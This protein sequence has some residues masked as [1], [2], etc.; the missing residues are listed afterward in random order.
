MKLIVD[1]GSTKTDWAFA[2]SKSDVIIA[3]SRGINP[4]VQD[5]SEIEKTFSCELMPFMRENGIEENNIS[6]VFFYGAGCTA[7]K[8][9]VLT[10]I[11]GGHFQNAS[12]VKVESDLLGAARSLCGRNKG[13][14][15]ILG[16]GANSCCY[17]GEKIVSKI[18]ALGYILGDEGSGAVLGRNFINGILK[19]WL[20]KE[21]REAFMSETKMTVADILERVYHSKCPNRFLASMS[22]FIANHIGDYCEL[23]DLVVENF[24][25]F[26][27]INIL[28]Y[29]RNE[30]IKWMH[31]Q[32]CPKIN[33]VGSVAFYYKSQLQRAMKHYG[34]V[35][36]HI[37]KSPLSGLVDYHF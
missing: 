18:P 4:V 36:G 22:E 27:R 16:T 26:I 21:I 13:I 33:A 12:V 2:K 5:K 23:E 17:D 9:P 15:A 25:N 32:C 11:I 37:K 6:S 29:L 7:V 35:I 31:G 19:G 8:T 20:P 28:P 1:S 14:A 3:C 34:L 10:S 24:D 30:S